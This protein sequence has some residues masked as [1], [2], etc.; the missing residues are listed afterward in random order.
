MTEYEIALLWAIVLLVASL[1]TGFAA[2]TNH[3]PIGVAMVLFVIGGFALYY[4][5]SL[6]GDG[7]LA[8]DIP[9]TIYK[10]YARF[11]T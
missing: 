9:K 2:V 1:F 4:A 11:L 8:A 6:S 5:N 7:N 3:R 10:L